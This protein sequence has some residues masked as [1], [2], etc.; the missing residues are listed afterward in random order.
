M[1]RTAP[2]STSSRYSSTSS[3]G[4][5][6]SLAQLK[7]R[8]DWR[9]SLQYDQ[10]NQFFFSDR[11][12]RRT[13]STH[14]AIPSQSSLFRITSLSSLVAPTSSQTRVNALPATSLTLSNLSTACFAILAATRST[15]FCSTGEEGNDETRAGT[16]VDQ[17]LSVEMRTQLPTSPRWSLV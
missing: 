1:A 14:A 10:C 6:R 3:N 17:L 2:S 9:A 11:R 5:I 12:D 8:Q 4:K 13:I 16:R 7:S 15:I